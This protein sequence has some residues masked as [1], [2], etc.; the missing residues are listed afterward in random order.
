MASLGCAQH[1]GM[2]ASNDTN[3]KLAPTTLIYGSFQPS[4]ARTGK[5]SKERLR[6][7]LEG[8]DTV[9]LAGRSVPAPSCPNSCS[10]VLFWCLIDLGPQLGWGGCLEECRRTSVP[11]ACSVATM[12]RCATSPI[13]ACKVGASCVE[14]GYLSRLIELLV[15]AQQPGRH[16]GGMQCVRP[17]TRRMLIRAQDDG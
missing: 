10:E 2:A 14:P 13:A 15:Q 3:N 4:S 7:F 1:L 17:S 6:G 8:R 12:M 16:I 11:S 9:L 5:P